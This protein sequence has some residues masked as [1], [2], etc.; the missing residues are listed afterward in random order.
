MSLEGE[1]DLKRSLETTFPGVSLGGD[2][3]DQWAVALRFDIGLAE[4]GR[5]VGKAR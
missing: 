5:T 3:F 1:F 4:I 2:L